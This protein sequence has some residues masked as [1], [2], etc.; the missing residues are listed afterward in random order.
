MLIEQSARFQPIKNRQAVSGLDYAYYVVPGAHIYTSACLSGKMTTRFYVSIVIS[1]HCTPFEL[2]VSGK[3]A[4]YEAAAIKPLAQSG[5]NLIDGPLFTLHLEPS[6]RHFRR[7]HFIPSPGVLRID[8]SLFTPFDAELQAA[9]NGQLAL[10]DAAR[11]IDRMVVVATNLL[12]EPPPPDSRLIKVCELLRSEPNISLSDVAAQLDLSYERTSH[13]FTEAMGLPFR[14]YQLWRKVRRANRLLWSGQSLTAAAHGAGFA[15]SAHLCR[16][17]QQVF[18]R[19]PSYF[20]D[21][22]FVK[23]IAAEQRSTISIL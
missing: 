4:P 16:I 13:L 21:R 3:S 6:H 7:F 5:K 14:S 20:Y 18:A 22:R 12:P 10:E 1:P 19:P 8:R 15:D 9:C 11:L 17:F 23:I 2:S